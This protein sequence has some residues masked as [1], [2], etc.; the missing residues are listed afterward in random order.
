VRICL[1]TDQDLEHQP[2]ADDDWPCDP[3][4][5]LPDAEWTVACLEKEDAVRRIITLHREGYDL[6]FNLCDGAWD[7]GRVGIELIQTLERLQAPFTGATSEFFEPSREAMKRVCRAWGLPTPGYLIASGLT[8]I[9]RAVDTLQFPLIVKHPSGYASIGLTPSS[10]VTTPRAL[11]R[12]AT[13]AISAYGSALIEEFIE[14]SECTVLVA[15]DPDDP[16]RP[17]TFTPVE[18]QFP[19]GESFK[20]EKLKWVD[21]GGLTAHPMKESELSEQVRQ[22]S[23]RFFVG[24]RGTGYGR[25]DF[26]VD[27]DGTPFILEIN[28]NCGLYYPASDYGSAD[29]CLAHDEIGH[30]G[31]TRLVVRSALERHR[32]TVP[33]WRVV[34]G[35]AGDYAVSATR[36][37]RRGDVVVPLEGI[38]HRLVSRSRIDA[39][40]E[41]SRWIRL[42]SHGRPITD[43]VWAVWSAEPEDWLPINHSCDPNCWIRELD[44]VAR[45]PIL[46]GEEITLEY[47]TFCHSDMEPFTCEC[48]ADRCRGLIQGTDSLTSVVDP[49]GDHVSDYVRRKRREHQGEP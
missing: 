49:F 9:E 31:F 5:F 34:P 28:P 20:H 46:P 40:A 19:E 23:A 4:P 17:R 35:L 2:L 29:L 24:M 18:Y 43:E 30:A 37:L 6:F 22:L 15:E 39:H 7:E 47:A 33:S 45:R 21:Y 8:D 44:V 10:R 25:C 26:R 14:G 32:R 36:D 12:R 38:A 3:R 41:R 42:L 13:R 1:L 48:G 11:L 16:Y 27:Q